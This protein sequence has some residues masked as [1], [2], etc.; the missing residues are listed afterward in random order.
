MQ[1]TYLSGLD[2]SFR[3]V[4]QI[5]EGVW[6]NLTDPSPAEIQSVSVS[7]GVDPDDLRAALDVEERS[8]ITAEEGYVLILVDVPTTELR[9]EREW[10]VTIPLGIVITRQAIITVCSQPSGV[11]AEFERGRLRDFRTFM[12]TRF[13]LQLLL[14]NAASYMAALHGIDKMIDK[15]AA[16]LRRST[17]N[18]ELI[19][20]MELEKSLV[21]INTS[22]VGNQRVLERLVR[23]S[24]V[25]KYPEDDDL[26]EDTMIE[27]EQAIEMAGIYSGILSGTMDAYA[28]I[29]ANNQNA[30]MKTLALVT[31][32]LS[33][34]T[35]IF[36]AY[37]MNVDTDGMP[38]AGVWW[39]F[40]VVIGI[41]FVIALVVLLLFIRKKW[42]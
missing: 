8:R 6:I 42:F 34:P 14:R 18:A 9:G 13:T 19:E 15:G 11:I 33:I 12:K 20:M 21:Y 1:A 41:T 25:K 38:F 3:E 40:A 17:R 7:C 26:L 16:S 24:A 36:S 2:G 4:D 22:L 29:I 10:Y 30:I 32:V 31:I 27:N 37:G 23:T 28:S 35:M 39:G 5:S